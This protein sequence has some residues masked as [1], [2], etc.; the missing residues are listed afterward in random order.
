MLESRAK[1][2]VWQEAMDKN[3]KNPENI[4]KRARGIRN[5][6]S[7]DPT[8]VKRR[9]DSRKETIQTAE[10]KET[11]GMQVRE[12]MRKTFNDPQWKA[13]TG[14]EKSKKIAELKRIRDKQNK[15]ECIHCKRMLDPANYAHWHGVNCKLNNEKAKA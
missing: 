13:T 9:I 10:W 1:N 15:K 14:V 12:N 8:Y 3:N 7:K 11:T 6:I 5:K 4:K 2:G